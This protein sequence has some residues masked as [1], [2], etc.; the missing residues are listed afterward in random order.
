MLWA[1]VLFP[2][3]LLEIDTSTA[4]TGA[5]RSG[6]GRF[7]KSEQVIKLHR[8]EAWTTTTTT[9][10]KSPAFPPPPAQP[11]REAEQ[12]HPLLLLGTTHPQHAVVLKTHGHDAA[13][14]GRER[15]A[16]NPEPV[17]P[18]QLSH[19]RAGGEAPNG[20]RRLV[21]PLPDCQHAPVPGK[22]Q[23]AYGLAGAEVPASFR[24]TAGREPEPMQ[25]LKKRRRGETPLREA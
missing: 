6:T 16:A 11:L 10:T 21:S 22:R 14:A 4:W 20:G 5:N 13:P 17:P 18:C 2:F 3:T 23:A 15:Y 7:R 24:G 1:S 12:R 25:E 19:D 9:T 8:S